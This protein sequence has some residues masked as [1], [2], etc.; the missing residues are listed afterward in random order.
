MKK[1]I[2]VKN[3]FTADEA[4]GLKVNELMFRSRVTRKDLGQVLG[5]SGQGMSRKVLGQVNWK[6]EE[7][8]DIA[9]FF[10]VTV[11][12]LLPRRIEKAPEEE[13]SSGAVVA[14]AGFEPTTSGL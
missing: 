1:L 3:S 10:G 7:L 5:V 12:D 2:D 6:I 11:A 13:T 14:G 9:D 4:I 8:Y